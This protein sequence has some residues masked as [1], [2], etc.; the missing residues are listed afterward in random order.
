MQDTTP[1]RFQV[2][3]CLKFYE[4][5]PSV[6]S[7][8]LKS[9]YGRGQNFIVD[10][11]LAE[12]GASLER[13]DQSDE[14]ML[15]LPG[16]ETKV[17]ITA[18]DETVSVEGYSLTILPPGRSRIYVEQG[19]VILRIFTSQADDLAALCLNRDSYLAPDPNVSPYRPWPEAIPRI[20]SYSLDVPEEAGR[21]GRIW[22]S[23][24]LMVNIFYP[25]GP[26]DRKKM[27]PHH[28]DD[29]QQGLLVLEGESIHHLRWPW[30][31][32]LDLWQEDEHLKCGAPSLTVIPPPAL[33]TSQMIGDNNI[34]VDIFSPP[35]EDFVAKEGW[36]LNS[37]DYSP[38]DTRD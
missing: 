30:T 29:F 8:H 31:S 20:R 14:Y 22:R 12:P 19:G 37:G 3:D 34:L 5:E 33:H 2:A 11:T 15:I 38:P 35:R 16:Q 27:T 23:S 36:I 7:P 25:Q 9:W 21:F 28:H 32:D 4:R 10:Y 17:T 26:R 24:N 13:A 6:E 1:D 18:G